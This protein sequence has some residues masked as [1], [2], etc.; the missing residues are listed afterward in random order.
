MTEVKN[1][2]EVP[3]ELSEFDIK[4]WRARFKEAYMK[5]KA[6]HTQK[7]YKALATVDSHYNTADGYGELRNVLDVRGGLVAV[8]RATKALEKF[9]GPQTE[10]TP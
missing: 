7:L 6:K 5:Y 10:P 9:L 1:T 4:T 2:Q 3:T 8:V